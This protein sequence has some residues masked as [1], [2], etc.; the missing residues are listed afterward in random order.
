[1]AR[2]RQHT[3]KQNMSTKR[4]AIDLTEAHSTA[5]KRAHSE[6]SSG[7]MLMCI[8]DS[9]EPTDVYH[10]M[11]WVPDKKDMDSYVHDR[12]VQLKREKKWHFPYVEHDSFE[13]LLGPVPPLRSPLGQKNEVSQ[14]TDG[15]EEEDEYDE[16]AM[17]R[18]FQS[19][20]KAHMNPMYKWPRRDYGR[21]ELAKVD[22]MV[23]YTEIYKS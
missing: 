11:F 10:Y 23:D 5:Q 8:N 2:H 17:T 18:A 16:W 22:F 14:E 20:F 15:D 1:M 6:V 7:P 4:N 19:F 12:L 3:G 9:S 13:G 21:D